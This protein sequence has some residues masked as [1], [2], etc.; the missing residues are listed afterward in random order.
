M[1]QA[2][3]L[4]RLRVSIATVSTEAGVQSKTADPKVHRLDDPASA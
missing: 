2:M 3:V 4:E 1:T